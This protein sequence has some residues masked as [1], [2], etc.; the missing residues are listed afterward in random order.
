MLKTFL[1]APIQ[2]KV[3]CLPRE[4]ITYLCR[5]CKDLREYAG[6]E[7]EPRIHVDRERIR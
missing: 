6:G 7:E 1:N 3:S 4:F 5:R 2:K